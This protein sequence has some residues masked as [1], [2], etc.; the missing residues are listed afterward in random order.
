MSGWRIGRSHTLEAGVVR[1]APSVRKIFQNTSGRQDGGWQ[2]RPPFPIRG[3]RH[4]SSLLVTAFP[5]FASA[6]REALG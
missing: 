1:R 5:L 2:R 3:G 6:C 4:P